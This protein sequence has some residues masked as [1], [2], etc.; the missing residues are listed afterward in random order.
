MLGSDLSSVMMAFQNI[1][2]GSIFL[3]T[4]QN[5][6]DAIRLGSPDNE[7]MFENL[8]SANT[9]ATVNEPGTLGLFLG[10]ALMLGARRRRL[11]ASRYLSRLHYDL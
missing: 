5:P 10:A 3:I 4:D 11:R 8:L 6:F 2:A 1:G 7:V 9:G